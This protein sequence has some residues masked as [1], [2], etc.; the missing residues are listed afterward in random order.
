MPL[1]KQAQEISAFVSPDILYQY[2]VMTFSMRNTP[3]T[4][5]HMITLV[6]FGLEGFAAYIHY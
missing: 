6:V 3:A 5:Q 2:T 4:F 1:R